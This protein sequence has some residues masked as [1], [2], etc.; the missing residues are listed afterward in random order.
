MTELV[1]KDAYKFKDTHGIPLYI[2]LEFA[3]DNGFI[4]D[5]LQYM[6]DAV[7]AGR[8]NLV[9]LV[10]EIVHAALDAGYLSKADDDYFTQRLRFCALKAVGIV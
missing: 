9:P 2:T 4:V 1:F 7:K 5:W 6:K 10:G 8:N 3:K